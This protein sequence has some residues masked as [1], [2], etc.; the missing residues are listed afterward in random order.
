MINPTDPNPNAPIDPN[1]AHLQPK[2][3]DRGFKHLPSIDNQ[4]GDTVRVYES[5]NAL[6]RCIWLNVNGSPNSSTIQLTD[7]Q[8]AMLMEQIT[9]LF[10]H[11][12]QNED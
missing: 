10:D 9:F 8:A 1:A 7:D 5:S 4:R 2:I 11:H 3:T 12:Y 6:E